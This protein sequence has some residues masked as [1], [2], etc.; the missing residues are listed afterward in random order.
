MTEETTELYYSE[1]FL[2]LYE[3]LKTDNNSDTALLKFLPPIND[4]SYA[5]VTNYDEI[6]CSWRTEELC[7]TPD[8][9]EQLFNQ[10]TRKEE[11]TMSKPRLFIDMD[12]TLARFHDEV[13]YLERMWEKDFFKDLK[14]FDNLVS[15]LEK[16][17]ETNNE[18]IEMYILTT[19]I[20]GEP[21]YC[22][23]EKDEWIDKHLPFID[24]YH[25]IFVPQCFTK[26][27]YIKEYF[28][29]ELDDT[30]ILF[31]DYNKN[32]REWEQHKG[33]AIKCVNNINNKGLGAYG[34][35]K[36]NLWDGYYINNC[37]DP[38]EQYSNFATL[39][40]KLTTIPLNIN[41]LNGTIKKCDI[42][43]LTDE[44]ELGRK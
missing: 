35:E 42:L 29:R 13:Q 2:T 16:L 18:D 34:G 38:D 19:T 10:F 20:D 1:K 22:R 3:I 15:A 32:L 5:C 17:N 6:N 28:G 25:R 9:A 12:G 21:P 27:D 23:T 37:I 41:N 14:P 24:S 31:D 33:T 39:I 30:D 4:K 26:P 40:S 8:E 44:D 11:K 43:D 36:G 7:S